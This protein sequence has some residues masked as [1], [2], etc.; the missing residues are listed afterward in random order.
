MLFSTTITS[1]TPIPASKQASKQETLDYPN[2]QK[3]AL[4]TAIKKRLRFQ[5]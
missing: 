4:R 2:L 3:E 1:L 5:Q